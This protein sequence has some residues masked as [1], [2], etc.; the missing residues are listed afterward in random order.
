M[1]PSA[2]ILATLALAPEV[3]PFSGLRHIGDGITLRRV[4]EGVADRGPLGLSLRDMQVDLALPGGFRGVY[5]IA[6]QE[7]DRDDLLFRQS[8]AVVASFS[9]SVYRQDKEGNV[10]IDVPPGTVFS[11]G[12]PRWVAETEHEAHRLAE[13]GALDRRDV[14]AAFTAGAAAVTDRA[15]LSGNL[16]LAR[17]TADMRVDLAIPS[18]RVAPIE[19]A[20]ERR[21]VGRA[22]QA[23]RGGE[24]NSGGN[25]ATV[26]S[27][28]DSALPRRRA[29]ADDALSEESPRFML[30]E[31]YR[32]ARVAQLLRGLALTPPDRRP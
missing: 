20:V 26:S 18:S 2:A 3:D 13:I 24:R 1:L 10:I 22:E 32:R 19:R 12:A 6:G 31:A 28:P 21:D 7:G 30:D 9:R 23:E 27:L 25:D 16:G 8:G 15:D 29:A 17:G 4:D 14:E 5:R 11:I